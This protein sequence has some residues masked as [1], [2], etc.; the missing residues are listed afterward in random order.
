MAVALISLLLCASSRE[1]V[2]QPAPRPARLGSSSTLPTR[3]PYRM[4]AGVPT[5]EVRTSNGEV[6]RA[7]LDTGLSVTVVARSEAARLGVQPG[8][9]IM[10]STPLGAIPGET[11]GN[12]ELRV[13]GLHLEEVPAVIADYPVFGSVNRSSDLPALWIGCSALTACG[14]LLDPET[15]TVTF[16]PPDTGIPKGARTVALST[17][18]GRAE[19]LCSANRGLARPWILSSGTPGTIIPSDAVQTLGLSAMDVR[20]VIGPDNT[21]VRIGTVQLSELMVGTVRTPG[22]KGVSV[23]SGN[24]AGTGV[25]GADI[26]LR[27]KVFVLLR[28][29][30]LA[31]IPKR[32]G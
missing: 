32:G 23:L 9:A 15:S 5:V 7:T 31:L 18:A 20:E 29:N 21:P 1:V 8:P 4:F 17:P 14:V 26:L 13:G 30:L 22:V 16:F 19:G 24:M 3:V 2:G 25:V 10:V 27:F 28:R 11:A 6:A 12:L